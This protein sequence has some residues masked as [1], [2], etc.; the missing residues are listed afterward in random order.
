LVHF[1]NTVESEK[2]ILVPIYKY[3][4]RNDKYFIASVFLDC[5]FY[6]DEN[7]TVATPRD[8][9]KLRGCA[10]FASFE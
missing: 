6:V 9:G 8:V 3:K 4:R 7:N 2:R 5:V 10:L 1:E